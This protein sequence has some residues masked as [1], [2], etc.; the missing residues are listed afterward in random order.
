MYWVYLVFILSVALADRHAIIIAPRANWDDYGVQSESCRM[1]KDLVAGGVNPENIILMS[2]DRVTKLE[3]NPFPGELFTD[4]SPASPGKDYAKGCIEHIDY[5]GTDMNGEVMLAIMRGDV[6]ELKK[7][8]KKEN[9]RALHS[10]A[11]DNIMLYFTSHGGPGEILVGE[12][13]VEE[14][15]LIST[16]QYMHDNKMYKNF[17]FLMEACYSGSMFTNLPKGLNVYAI[18]AADDDHSSYESHCPPDDVID[19]ES[20]DT[21]LSCYWDNAMEWFMEGGSSHS[22]DELYKHTHEKVADHSTQ[23]VSHFGDIEEM[24]KMT[25]ADFMGEIPAGRFNSI[26]GS[27]DKVAK[28]DVPRHLAMW[29]AIRADKNE[30]KNALADYERIVMTE[31]K[32]EVEVM[33]L[34]V[35]LMNEK[36]ADS[37][38]KAS[39]ES[40][41]IDCVR[42]LS[43]SLVEK[44]G[45]S[46]PLNEKSMN[47]LK[48]ICLPGVSVPNVD[49]SEI[50]M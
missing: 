33:R 9:P 10:T 50:C 45:H 48:N 28:S 11:E 4:D 49:F 8:T 23:N 26:K 35:A 44:C 13:V 38:M 40:Y 7:L 3:D 37:A 41:S 19:G 24:G 31:A 34:G 21:C 5:D 15:D 47:M 20:M 12:T 16:I 27:S 29:R 25:L 22:L 39:A 17:L 32:K 30:L 18:T 2:D 43:H 36:A 1:Y 46:Y 14:K 42:E 6:E